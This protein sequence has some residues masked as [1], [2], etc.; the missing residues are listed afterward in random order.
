MQLFNLRGDLFIFFFPT[1]NCYVYKVV[2]T[3][4]QSLLLDSAYALVYI[5]YISVSAYE[6]KALCKVQA[7]LLLVNQTV[8]AVR[9][10]A[11][12]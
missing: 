10:A 11:V 12:Q 1:D 7:N 2:G 4:G 9:T 5:G 3:L 6:E 8:F